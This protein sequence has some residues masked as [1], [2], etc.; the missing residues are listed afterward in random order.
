M[1]RR[2]SAPTA[3]MGRP[4]PIGMGGMAGTGGVMGAVNHGQG[5]QGECAGM[6]GTPSESVMT[7]SRGV[8]FPLFVSTRY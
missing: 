3:L 8:S 1:H 7:L 5:F 6:V 2:P 4:G